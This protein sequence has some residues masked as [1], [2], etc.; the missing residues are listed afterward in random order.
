MQF[1][2][3][4]E[5]KIQ[6]KEFDGNEAVLFVSPTFMHFFLPPPPLSL[7]LSPQL[8]FS[9]SLHL[10]PPISLFSLF[11]QLC[12]STSSVKEFTQF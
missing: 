7:S 4:F 8:S 6:W 11:S 2:S 9:I 3:T 10:P 1:C 12:P 5:A